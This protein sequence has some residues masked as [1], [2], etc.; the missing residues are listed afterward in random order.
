[1]PEVA[2]AAALLVEPAP[3]PLAEALERVLTDPALR[4]R[5]RHAGLERA[6]A[7]SWER[8]AAQTLAVY[9]AAVG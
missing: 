4:D 8:T 2:G 9:R 7:F 1:L 5:L 6:R 3:E